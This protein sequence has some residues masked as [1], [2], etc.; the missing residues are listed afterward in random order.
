[1]WER[2]PS[3]VFMVQILL[4]NET[5]QNLSTQVHVYDFLNQLAQRLLVCTNSQEC[6]K[7]VFTKRHMKKII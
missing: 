2:Q 4:R 1:M 6:N 7:N 5:K 3:L